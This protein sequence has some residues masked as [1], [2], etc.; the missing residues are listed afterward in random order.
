[1]KT[2]ADETRRDI[3]ED[4]IRERAYLLWLEDGQPEG[5]ADEHWHKARADA[6]GSISK[7]DPIT[8]GADATN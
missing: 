2:T 4:I 6:L 5:R 8:T 7:T 3:D 1:M